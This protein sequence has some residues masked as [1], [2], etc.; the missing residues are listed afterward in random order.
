MVSLETR[1]QVV[2]EIDDLFDQLGEIV[3]TKKIGTRIIYMARMDNG[4]NTMLTRDDFRLVP[5]FELD[6][7]VICQRVSPGYLSSPAGV[8]FKG[9]VRQVHI[10]ED[11]VEYELAQY[12]WTPK[13]NWLFFDEIELDAI[14]GVHHED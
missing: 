4:R 3:G 9:I 6:Q 13:N 10:L 5:R 8:G 1:I 12:D 11:K 14:V 2:T 7:W